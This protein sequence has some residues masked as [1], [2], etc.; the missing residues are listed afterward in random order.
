MQQLTHKDYG[1]IS[2]RSHKLRCCNQCSHR[3]GRQRWCG[4]HSRN[5]HRNQSGQ[6]SHSCRSKPQ[7]QP[8]ACKDHGIQRHNQH[9]RCCS[10]CSHRQ[11]RQQ[12]CGHHSHNRHHNQ[13]GQSSRSC[14]SKPQHQ[15]QPHA[16]RCHGR[17][18]TWRGHS[19]RC[20][21]HHSHNHRSKPRRKQRRKGKR[22]QRISC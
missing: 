4:H 14:H 21:D 3:Q 6:S 10:Q 11:G 19:R 9:S 22:A 13:S 17:H 8:H 16:C 20:G 15:P 7:H 12:W 2:N 5:R 18:R 1:E